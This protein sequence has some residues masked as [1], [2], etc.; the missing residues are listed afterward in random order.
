MFLDR[1]DIDA[2][3]PLSRVE[4]GPFSEHLNVVCGPAGAGKT[5]LA[6]F[7][8]DSLVQ[9]EYPL[10]MMSSSSGCVV[11]ADR[12]GLLHCRREKDGTATGRR[13]VQFDPRGD[14]VQPYDSLQQSWI[15]EI[16]SSTDE[17]RA[18]Q[19]IQIPESIV[20]G[21]ITDTAITSVARVVSACVRSGLDDPSTLEAMPLHRSATPADHHRRQSLRSQLADVEAELA[22]LPAT[23]KSHDQLVARRNEL[24]ARLATDRDRT[25]GTGKNSRSRQ[26]SRAVE[27]E[28]RIGRL[29][30]RQTE[31]RQSIAELEAAIADRLSSSQTDWSAA[32]Q[33]DEYRRRQLDDLDAQTSRWQRTLAEVHSLR[34]ALARSAGYSG[35]GYRPG[36]FPPAIDD[37]AARRRH[38]DG[39]LHNGDRHQRTANLQP[40]DGASHR[41][42][43]ADIDNRI[44]AATRQIDWLL[45]RYACDDLFSDWYRTMPASSYGTRA[46]L[47]DALR[48]IRRELTEIRHRTRRSIAAKPFYSHL[49]RS[50]H[51]EIDEL[52]R[53]EQWLSASIDQLLQRRESLLHG[54]D[55]NIRDRQISGRHYHDQSWSLESLQRKRARRASDLER[56]TLDLDDCQSRA[57]LLRTAADTTDPWY[58]G[59]RDGDWIDRDAI[60]AEIKHI[61][62]LL[63]GDSRTRWLLTRRSQLMHELGVVGQQ[64]P[65]RSPL[66]E[67]A[68]RW[69]VRLS[70]GRLRNV[71]WPFAA[72]KSASLA[73]SIH[74]EGQATG[75]CID[76]RDESDCPPAD[77]A[78][79]ALA[80]RMAAGNLLAKTGRSVPLVLEIQPEMQQA[81]RVS[82]SGYESSF[83]DWDIHGR[84]NHPI[85]AALHDYTRAAAPGRVADQQ[86]RDCQADSPR[87]RA[88]IPSVCRPPGSWSSSAMAS[89]LRSRT[90][91]RTAS[92][93]LRQ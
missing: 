12:N 76:G 5:A 89:P 71:A 38:L 91:R 83:H 6:R 51:G 8:R 2:H 93:Y 45:E 90:I 57:T 85:I 69:L 9:R 18:A 47:V 75:V 31:L 74:L 25:V 7:I 4:L 42:T 39:L 22:R 62:A 80:V 64:P 30:S 37:V 46:T 88:S 82:S 13:T 28:Q 49:Q 79:T 65:S 17:S 48:A 81:T 50:I 21:V 61:D 54:H 32:V 27:L 52:C 19:S 41:P 20:D 58:D 78:L 11:W 92:A 29:R 40:S 35:Q 36:Y 68:S 59:P 77:R 10:G 84:R 3:G 34:D 86:P 73:H 55:R 1:I 43:S 53:C 67:E 15:G 24:A 14:F 44:D 72:F 16:T 60:T 70:A 56:V 23:P 33:S 87:R 63:A 66:A 26:A